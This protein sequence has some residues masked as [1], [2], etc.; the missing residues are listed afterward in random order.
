MPE[1]VGTIIDRKYTHTHIYIYLKAN[2]TIQARDADRAAED[3]LRKAAASGTPP[4]RHRHNTT[5]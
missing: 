1:I 3:G 4:R 5:Q 2:V